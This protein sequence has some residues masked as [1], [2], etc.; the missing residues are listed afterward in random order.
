M[1]ILMVP[2]TS[3]LDHRVDLPGGVDL[4]IFRSWRA[5]RRRH[6]SGEDNRVEYRGT[7]FYVGLVAILL[8]AL[9]LLVVAVQNT[10]EVEV[11]F[12][13]LELTVPLFGVA[14]GA[15]ILAVILDELIGLVWRR[16]RRT[17]L[18]ERAELDRLR[19]AGTERSEEGARVE[20]ETE[21]RDPETGRSAETPGSAIGDQERKPAEDE[22]DTWSRS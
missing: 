15:A 14:I 12:F 4:L 8:F 6:M 22:G 16:Q 13:G 9:A 17:R 7:G 10:Q 18:E 5:A 11:D 19:A 3:P 2:I 1:P 21:K 20:E